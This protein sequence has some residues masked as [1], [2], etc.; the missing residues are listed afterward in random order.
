[1]NTENIAKR[2]K[3]VRRSKQITQKQLA[4]KMQV[5]Q[6]AIALWENGSRQISIPLLDQFAKNLNVSASYLLYGEP[7]VN[8]EAFHNNEIAE[9]TIQRI[10]N[11][12]QKL[13]D[14]GQ[15]KA[16]EQVEMLT[17]IP[18]YQ[19]ATPQNSVHLPNAAHER[20]GIGF[21]PEDRQAD[22]D[23]INEDD[24]TQ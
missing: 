22:E 7:D 21:T 9:S 24:S 10:L 12:Y 15:D 18:E 1:M 14:L 19:K 2:I 20:K 5:S 23:M 13:N 3:E 8:E 17:K 6:T 16:V 4:E 11:P